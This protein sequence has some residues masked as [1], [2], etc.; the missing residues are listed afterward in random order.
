MRINLY[1]TC[2]LR[3]RD[4]VSSLMKVKGQVYEVAKSMSPSTF[5]LEC[6]SKSIGIAGHATRAR[7]PGYRTNLESR[8]RFWC[9]LM[10]ANL[11]VSSTRK[12]KW[13]SYEEPATPLEGLCGNRLNTATQHKWLVCVHR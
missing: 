6:R 2:I 8:A 5:I 12:T 13:I 7:Y 9:G 11:N 3:S 10:E 1:S 4:R